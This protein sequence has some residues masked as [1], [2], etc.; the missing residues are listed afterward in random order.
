MSEVPI[1]IIRPVA[2]PVQCIV[3]GP[4]ISAFV[5]RFPG[6]FTLVISSIS[7]MRFEPVVDPED[8]QHEEMREWID[9]KFD[10]EAFSPV[11]ATRRMKSGLRDWRPMR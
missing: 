5:A 9:R 3:W 4:L 6:F 2:V 11:A 7:A 8:E 1:R 10:P